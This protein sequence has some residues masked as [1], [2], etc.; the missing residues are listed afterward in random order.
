MIVVKANALYPESTFKTAEE[1]VSH[2]REWA[3][4]SDDA[5]LHNASADLIE[6]LSVRVFE[7]E[8]AMNLLCHGNEKPS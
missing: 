2:L 4:Y 6:K 1:F 5:V 7:L 8:A 3:H